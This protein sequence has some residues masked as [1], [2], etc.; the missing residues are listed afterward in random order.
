MGI[1]KAEVDASGEKEGEKTEIRTEYQEDIERL[2][3]LMEQQ[4]AAE[5]P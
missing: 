1:K 5:N 3:Y 2:R 4:Q